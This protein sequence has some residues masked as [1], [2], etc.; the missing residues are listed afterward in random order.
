MPKI[1]LKK[2]RIIQFRQCYTVA[3]VSRYRIMAMPTPGMA[4][5]QAL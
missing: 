5:T 3:P 4:T 1:V 2:I